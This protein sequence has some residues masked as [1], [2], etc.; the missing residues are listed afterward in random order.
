MAFAPITK[1]R[2]GIL[3]AGILAVLGV[4]PDIVRADIAPEMYIQLKREAEE[5]LQI[6]IT[7][8]TRVRDEIPGVLSFRI[9]AN[10]DKVERS[11]A[12]YQAGET[13]EFESWYVTPAAWRSGFSGPQSPPLLQTG[14]QGRIYLS[15][16]HFGEGGLTPAAYG[17]SFEPFR[18]G[19]AT[20]QPRPAGTSRPTTRG[21]WFRR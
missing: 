16:N 8:V 15:P 17:R 6:K 14:W 18:T 10:I 20:V 7:K 11:K 3:V 21:R 13:V 9:E 4:R 1:F 5:V 12:G 19:G 2:G